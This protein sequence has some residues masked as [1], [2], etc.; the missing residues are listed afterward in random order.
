MLGVSALYDI[1]PFR[2]DAAARVLSFEGQ[3]LLAQWPPTFRMLASCYAHMGRLDDARTTPARLKSV[4]S[5]N[6]R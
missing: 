1:G 3:P 6:R 2:L 4:M 5:G